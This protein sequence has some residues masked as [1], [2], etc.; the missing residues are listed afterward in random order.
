MTVLRNLFR[1]LRNSKAA[2]PGGLHSAERM[3]AILSRERMRADRGNLGFA[4]LTFS[5]AKRRDEQH[6]ATLGSVIC[7]RIRLTDDAGHLGRRR[8][9]IV[10]P[11]TPASGAWTLAEDLCR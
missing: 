1:A 6:L 9:G 4:L 11:E 10:L 2:G 3:Q 5:L 8:I 7:N